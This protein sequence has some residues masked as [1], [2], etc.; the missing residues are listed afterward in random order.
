MQHR[1]YPTRPETPTPRRSRPSPCT[2][3]MAGG[4]PP[5]LSVGTSP[6]G[7]A[8]RRPPREP[9]SG[10]AAR[11]AGPSGPTVTPGSPSSWPGSVPTASTTRRRR[12]DG[13]GHRGHRPQPPPRLRTAPRRPHGR[14]G[15]AMTRRR[16]GLPGQ[17]PLPTARLVLA[18]CRCLDCDPEPIQARVFSHALVETMLRQ[19]PPADRLP[20]G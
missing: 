3:C 7:A 16:C 10:A 13:R 12:P 18:A 2:C 5:A 17:P 6:A 19:Q 14:G 4:S 20:A 1:S 8:T 9:G 15:G 11:S